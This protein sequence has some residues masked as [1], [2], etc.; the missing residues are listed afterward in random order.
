MSP[1]RQVPE[2]AD[3]SGSGSSD[4][5]AGTLR[6]YRCWNIDYATVVQDDQWGSPP[7]YQYGRYY[8][9]EVVPRRMYTVGRLRSVSYDNWW[10]SDEESA[11]CEIQQGFSR[12]HTHPP[13]NSSH[14]QLVVYTQTFTGSSMSVCIDPGC[15]DNKPEHRAPGADCTCGIYGWYSPDDPLNEHRGEVVGVT[16]NSGKIQ[17][18]TRGFRTERSKILAIAPTPNTSF[19]PFT[20]HKFR[21]MFRVQYPR[22]ETFLSFQQLVKRYPPDYDTVENLGIELYK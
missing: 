12:Y 5:V 1:Y 2:R 22:V 6:G 16:E 11:S 9:T 13:Q 10:Q 17:L 18:G 19:S 7:L 4:L 15:P 8:S 3:F 21:E 20:R 14:H